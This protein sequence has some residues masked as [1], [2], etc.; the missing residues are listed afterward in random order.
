MKGY[1]LLDQGRQALA[2]GQR[3]HQQLPVNLLLRVAGEVVEQI[4][5]IGPDIVTGAEQAQV[6]VDSSGFGVVV[7]GAHMVV[8]LDAFP[9]SAHHQHDLAVGFEPH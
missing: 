3:S 2:Q 6:G 5:N 7:A 4:R 9:L 8:A 1:F